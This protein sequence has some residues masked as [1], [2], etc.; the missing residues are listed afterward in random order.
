M[1]ELGDRKTG[2]VPPNSVPAKAGAAALP[3]IKLVVN[4]QLPPKSM[5][6]GKKVVFASSAI[7]GLAMLG[8][9]LAYRAASAKPP[10]RPAAIVDHLDAGELAALPEPLQAGA[11]ALMAG[12]FQPPAWFQSLDRPSGGDLEYPVHEAIDE[13]QP[14]LRWSSSAPDYR[15]AVISPAHQVVARAEIYGEPH[16]TLPVELPRGAVYTWEVSTRG[17][18]RRNSFRVLDET[19]SG[20]LSGLRLAHGQSHLLIGLASFELGLFSNAQREFQALAQERPHSPEAEQLL[21]NIDHFL[22]SK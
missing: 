8:A 14:T 2:N 19:E 22:A 11:Q 21:R 1:M 10:A 17:Q 4:Q 16:W 3:D 13:V 12:T 18:V 15:V 9:Y 20:W 7:A 6:A 5:L